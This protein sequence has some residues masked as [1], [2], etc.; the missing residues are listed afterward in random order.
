MAP[1]TKEQ[2]EELTEKIAAFKAQVA[3]VDTAVKKFDTLAH[4]DPAAQEDVTE[5]KN[6]LA[7]VTKRHAK[8]EVGKTDSMS[9]VRMLNQISTAN[10]AAVKLVRTITQETEEFK[11][12][13]WK[14][15]VVDTTGS[16]VNLSRF[17][18]TF[19]GV[20]Y[21]IIVDNGRGD[22]GDT[23][24]TNK[25]KCKHWV[26]GKERIFGNY[27]NGRLTFIGYGRHTGKGNSKYTVT[28]IRGGTTDATTA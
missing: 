26:S 19:Q 6:T 9:Y 22:H 1:I 18:K 15:A 17:D 5:V 24:L 21:K 10:I 28:L 14:E 3:K 25:T 8:L 7:D 4:R 16:A 2:K 20:L 11:K 23:Q 13:G 27:A 12:N